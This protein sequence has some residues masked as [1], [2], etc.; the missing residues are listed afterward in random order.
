MHCSKCSF[1]LREV[2]VLIFAMHWNV[3]VHMHILLKLTKFLLKVNI[4]SC[5]TYLR[6]E[7][8]GIFDSIT[9][10]KR[11]VGMKFPIDEQS[12]PSSAIFYQCDE[13]LQ[14]VP[15]SLSSSPVDVPVQP[16]SSDS[17]LKSAS[18]KSSSM[19]S[20]ASK[21]S[22][23]SFAESSSKEDE[24]IDA[25]LSED[26]FSLD[27]SWDVVSNEDEASSPKRCTTPVQL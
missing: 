11:K 15:S 14:Q 13:P 2:S 21:S 8:L 10:L 5:F 16:V 26:Y 23:S 20:L 4:L 6:G 18:S 7:M 1:F 3:Y 19:E 22:W 27:D 24:K 17:F 25:E 12:L 9:E